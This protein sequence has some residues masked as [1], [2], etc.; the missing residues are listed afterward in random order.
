VRLHAGVDFS[1]EYRGDLPW[2]ISGA[3][4]LL[5]ARRK[6]WSLSGSAR[7]GRPPALTFKRRLDVACLAHKAASFNLYFGVGGQF[8][9]ILLEMVTRFSL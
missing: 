8:Y 9:F 1:N 5:T 4:R 6:M 2:S 3:R 7:N